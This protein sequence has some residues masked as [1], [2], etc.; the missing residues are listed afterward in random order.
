MPDL[1]VVF[2]QFIP[3]MPAVQIFLYAAIK[4]VGNKLP[5]IS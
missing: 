2:T 4:S 1:L 3:N 5:R